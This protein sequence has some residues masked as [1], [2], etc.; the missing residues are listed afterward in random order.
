MGI[1]TQELLEE[2]IRLKAALT[3][4][5]DKYEAL[6]DKRLE[7]CLACK[8]F[9]G[10]LSRNKI[11]VAVTK[12]DK[13][14]KDLQRTVNYLESTFPGDWNNEEDKHNKVV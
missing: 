12:I 5:T 3:E 9:Y 8:N 13:Q 4:L 1:N 10:A 14:L 11:E 6:K 2:N 7:K